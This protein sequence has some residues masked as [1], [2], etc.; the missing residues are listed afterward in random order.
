[1]NFFKKYLKLKLIVPW[2]QIKKSMQI[3][4]LTNLINKES[5]SNIISTKII[6][7]MEKLA[8]F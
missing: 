3:L 5:T 1:M 7:S 4:L 8:R 2:Q 6:V